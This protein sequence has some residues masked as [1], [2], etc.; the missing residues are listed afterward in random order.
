MNPF[1]RRVRVSGACLL[2]RKAREPRPWSRRPCPGSPHRSPPLLQRRVRCPSHPCP[3]RHSPHRQLRLPRSGWERSSVCSTQLPP[4]PVDTI[5]SVPA[6]HSSRRG[7]TAAELY[8]NRGFVGKR[9]SQ[10]FSSRHNKPH[11]RPRRQR[12]W[13]PPPSTTS[14]YAWADALT[15]GGDG[16][17]ARP[18]SECRVRSAPPVPLRRACHLP[19]RRSE[20][21]TFIDAFTTSRCRC[22]ATPWRWLRESTVPRCLCVRP[23]RFSARSVR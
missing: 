10:R 4:P 8:S 12:S 7:K 3:D 19:H 1:L 18:A 23:S 9:S 22:R 17:S 6:T 20:R 14:R 13:R 5:P 16:A 21:S 15:A 2:R 11:R